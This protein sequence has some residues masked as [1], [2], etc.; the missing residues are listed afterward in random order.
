MD[1][2]CSLQDVSRLYRQGINI[3]ICC[4]FERCAVLYDLP[5]L[6]YQVPAVVGDTAEQRIT[7]KNKYDNDERLRRSVSNANRPQQ[8]GR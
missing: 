2:I 3:C 6:G 8:R 7:Y 4:E 5:V 1:K